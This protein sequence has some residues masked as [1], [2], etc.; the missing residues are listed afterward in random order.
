MSFW[1]VHRVFACSTGHVEFENL[2]DSKFV[3]ASVYMHCIP[4]Q[5]QNAY[6]SFN[7]FQS[8]GFSAPWVDVSTFQFLHLNNSIDF[9]S[10][11]VPDYPHDGEGCDSNFD[12]CGDCPGN[13]Y[14]NSYQSYLTLTGEPITGV[15]KC[16]QA[17]TSVRM[18][19]ELGE[20]A[21]GVQ[22]EPDRAYRIVTVDGGSIYAPHVQYRASQTVDPCAGS[23]S[24]SDTINGGSSFNLTLG[25]YYE[26]SSTDCNT[27]EVGSPLGV[28]T[29]D[30][31]GNRVWL[32][33]ENQAA[34]QEETQWDAQEPPCNSDPC[35][36][37][38]CDPASTEVKQ[39]TYVTKQSAAFLSL[40]FEDAP[41][42]L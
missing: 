7:I 14:L 28:F 41:P 13:R 5:N 2:A 35:C 12:C 6:S 17:A 22:A 21:P 10:Y 4:S 11:D 15:D 24:W 8:Y 19:S 33:I 16:L 34:Q 38:V 26:L 9:E 36:D 18:G 25:Q 30:P 23:S 3:D 42:W 32:P 27:T 29:T 1:W 31:S 40:T 39:T 37:H 20:V